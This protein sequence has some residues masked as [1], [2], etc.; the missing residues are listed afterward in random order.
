MIPIFSLKSAAN[1]VCYFIG[2]PFLP[3]V[4]IMCL[5]KMIPFVECMLGLDT[6]RMGDLIGAVLLAKV[7][8][9]LTELDVWSFFTTSLPCKAATN[10]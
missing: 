1:L 6:D 3:F 4:N 8:E 10:Y 5:Q 9:L 2:H 7:V